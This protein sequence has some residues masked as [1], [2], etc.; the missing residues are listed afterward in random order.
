MSVNQAEESAPARLDAALLT[1]VGV[2]VLGGMMSY[3]DA[4]IVNV[5]ISTL[6][7]EFD[8]PLATI[9][10][11]TTGYLLAVAFAIPL[12]SWATVR[13]GAKR[14]WLLG[15]TLFLAGSALCA[16]AWNAESLIA[17]RILQG[18]GGG[19]VDPIMMTV[20]ARAA[21]PKRIGRVM[22]LIS[23]PITLGPVV[24]P[25]IGGV[26]LE[27][28]S[29][30]WLFLVNLPFALAAIL[31][32]LRVLP[33]DP[34]RDGTPEPL[35]ILGV[36]LLCPGFAALV[37]A[38]SQAGAGGFGSPQV[39]AGLAG[40]LLLFTGYAFHA[41]RTAKTPLL[42]LRLFSSKGF[43][44]S[45]TTMFLLGGGLFS[46]LF[47]LPLYYQDVHGRSVLESGLLLAPLGLGTLI[48]MPV[49]GKLADTY[50]ARRLVPTGAVLIAAGSLVFTQSGPDTSQLPLTLAQLAAGFG[51]GL[52][53]APTMGSAYRTVP[54]DAV[55]GAT[56]AIFILN[57]IGASL[58]I[59]VIVL[60][61]QGNGTHTAP[62]VQSFGNAFWWPFAAAAVVFLTGLLLP[63]KPRPTPSGDP[64]PSDT[65]AP[66]DDLVP[67]R[68]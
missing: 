15:L 67:D 24:G 61:L 55:G 63:G 19:M 9:E 27:Q 16:L 25:L 18:L 68:T 49:A 65:P 40:G 32:A 36:L 47:L 8:A 44:A 42:D 5:G 56:G 33:A 60:I 37:F 2:M 4:T 31:L 11:V 48:G 13:F 59:A 26:L 3:L 64:A 20:V 34:P 52:V 29:W 41:L 46:L 21:G 22:G 12:A 50:G 62:T 7:G 51:M 30:Q 45:V 14:M 28:L 6:G 1:V 43:T 39:I 10:W 54:S 38:L 58:G 23:I 35:D 53:G 17:F 66:H 57:Q